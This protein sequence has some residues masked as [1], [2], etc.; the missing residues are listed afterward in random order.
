MPVFKQLNKYKYP[1]VSFDGG[2]NTKDSPSTLADNESPDMYNCVLDERGAVGTRQGI[3]TFTT[4]AV[5]A[6]ACD[7][8]FSYKRETGTQVMMGWYGGSMTVITG[9]TF[10]S[11]PS[12]AGV[13]TAGRPVEMMQF[14]NVAFMCNGADTPYKYNGTEFT[15]WGVPAPQSTL[16]ELNGGA[17]SSQA[18]GTYYYK[19]A[20]VN[21]YVIGG[22][23]GG[24]SSGITCN[25]NSGVSV[26]VPV[27]PVSYGV[28]TRW[29]YRTKASGSTFFFHS[30]IG[31]NTTTSVMDA[32]L[33][34]SLGSE[35]P[36]TSTK[37]VPGSMVKTVQNLNRVYGFDN[38]DPTFLKYTAYDDPYNWPA[39]YFIPI[40][41]GEGDKIIDI[42]VLGNN[43]V[44]VKEN[45]VYFIYTPDPTDETSWERRKAVA[46]VGGVSQR[47]MCS[48]GNFLCLMGQK[49]WQLSGVHVL[50][51]SG[52]Q[53]FN[54]AGELQGGIVADNISER[55]EPDIFDIDRTY[56]SKI[57]SIVY[58]N[59]A[60]WATPHDAAYPDRLYVLDIRKRSTEGNVGAWLR[61]NGFNPSCFAV[62][63]GNLYF[64]N[65]VADGY[66]YQ[67]EDGTYNDKDAA[68]DSYYW[69]KEYGGD[70]EVEDFWKDFR[71]FHFTYDF[72]N[73]ITNLQMGIEYNTTGSL[74]WSEGSSQDVS[75]YDGVGSLW[76]SFVWSDDPILGAK[77]QASGTDRKTDSIFIPVR[78]KKIEF[79]F[80]NKNTADYYFK[81]HKANIFMNVRGTR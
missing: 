11:V 15:R 68:I 35:M 9:T 32:L 65:S 28:D 57:C 52:L 10:E 25:G 12:A 49:N 63:N 36:S 77:W 26:N 50:S 44:V 33:D 47:G 72:P 61:W 81:I 1:I 2:L 80:N 8:L 59:K 51:E 37:G 18:T 66:I 16:S 34:A 48:F 13:Y 14:Q 79:K 54:Q 30:D 31:D 55:I 42:G 43:I 24:L 23:V 70:I 21:S 71:E 7:G 4:V 75:L 53:E 5:G 27:A 76:G 45:S 22:E 6:K 60:Y 40:S 38:A 20:Y 19:M 46:N 73:V 69:T 67:M 17:L 29:L 3:S 39:S 58:K 78:G 62:H 41:E 74:N 56:Q 64:G